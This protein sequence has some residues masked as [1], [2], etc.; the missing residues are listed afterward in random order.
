MVVSRITG[1]HA[2]ESKSTAEL[3][4]KQ[5]Y[6]GEAAEGSKASNAYLSMS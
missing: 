5:H 4:T 1:M 2:C 6:K 3:A